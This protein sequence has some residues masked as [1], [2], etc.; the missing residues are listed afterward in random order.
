MKSQRPHDEKAAEHYRDFVSHC[1]QQLRQER[2]SKGRD[3][4][5][6]EVKL[7]LFLSLL[8]KPQAP[9]GAAAKAA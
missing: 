4:S 5:L 8:D 9:E 3:F 6:A 1:Y 2:D 7:R